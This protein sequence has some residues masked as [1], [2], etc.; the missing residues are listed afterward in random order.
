MIITPEEPTLEGHY[1]EGTIVT[2]SCDDGYIGGGNSTC[3]RN[4]SWASASCS[5]ELLHY[6]SIYIQLSIQIHERFFKVLGI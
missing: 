4:G 3:Q 5:C 6:N 2:V 1:V